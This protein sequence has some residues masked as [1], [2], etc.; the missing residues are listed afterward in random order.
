MFGKM[1]RGAFLL[2]LAV[3]VMAWAWSASK[4]NAADPNDQPSER[5]YS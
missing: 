5:M 4:T 2:V 1:A 3:M